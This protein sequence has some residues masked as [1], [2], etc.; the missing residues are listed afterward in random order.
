MS[1][2]L[3]DGPNRIALWIWKMRSTLMSGPHCSEAPQAKDGEL[4]TTS[5][6]FLYRN[7]IHRSVRFNIPPENFVQIRAPG[8]GNSLYVLSRY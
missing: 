1:C 3:C 5:L 8:N 4:A 6:W 7:S 2:R